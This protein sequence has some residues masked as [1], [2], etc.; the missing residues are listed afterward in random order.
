LPVFAASKADWGGGGKKSA[1]RLILPFD[2]NMTLWQ[3]FPNE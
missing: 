3:R 1:D 2:K